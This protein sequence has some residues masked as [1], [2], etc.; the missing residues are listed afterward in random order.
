MALVG[1]TKKFIEFPY[2]IQNCV[3]A[4]TISI[5]ASLSFFGSLKLI[6]N[7]LNVDYTEIFKISIY[8]SII[9]L[10]VNLCITFFSTKIAINKCLKMTLDDYYKF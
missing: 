2:L 9:I 6:V 5:L 10:V 1:A 8:F 4:L 7:Y 3:S